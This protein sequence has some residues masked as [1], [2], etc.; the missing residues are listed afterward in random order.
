MKNLK[1]ARRHTTQI[2]EARAVGKI[3]LLNSYAQKS[4]LN[5]KTNQANQFSIG[6]V[7][8]NQHPWVQCSLI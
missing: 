1:N 3:P 4:A 2:Y 8:K 5:L 7:R 6:Y